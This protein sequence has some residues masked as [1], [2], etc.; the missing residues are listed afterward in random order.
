MLNDYAS[1]A[2]IEQDGLRDYA[3]MLT[4]EHPK[5]EYVQQTVTLIH[6]IA[7]RVGGPNGAGEY[8]YL[9]LVK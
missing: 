8:P 1:A 2:T 7:Q 3:R 9:T 4:A 5:N 6:G